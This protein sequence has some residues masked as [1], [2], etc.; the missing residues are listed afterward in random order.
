MN[1]DVSE[2]RECRDCGEPFEIGPGERNFYESR[3]LTLPK[4][5][6]PCREF[7]RQE[8]AQAPTRS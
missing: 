5:C 2:S 3:G 7:K 1:N 6:P 8:R 4:R